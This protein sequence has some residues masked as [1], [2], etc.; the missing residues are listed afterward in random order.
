MN[1]IS[2]LF[3]IFLSLNCFTQQNN[4]LFLLH[5]LPQSNLMNPATP[6]T[7]KWYVG[8]P[9][10]SSIHF[11]Y[12]NSSFSYNQI[13]TPTN[14]SYEPNVTGLIKRL[15]SRNSISTELH[16][17][18]FALAYRKEENSF[19]FTITEKNNFLFTYP[20]KT[21][22][23]LLD[24]NAQ[25]VGEKVGITGS[26]ISFNHYREY[27]L[28]WSHELNKKTTFGVKGKLLFGKLN[29]STKTLDFNID[30]DETTYNL[31]FTGELNLRMSLPVTVDILDNRFNGIS[32]NDAMSPV[33]L[34]LNRKNPGFAIDLGVI[35]KYSRKVELSASI[36]DLGFIRWKSNL[37]NLN[38]SGEFFFDGFLDASSDSFFKNLGDTIINAL[39]LTNN[40][41]KYV[42]FLSPKLMAGANYKINE[43]F[44]SG[45]IAQ[46]SIH[47]RK[48]MTSLTLMGQF[49]P[50]PWFG[51]AASYSFQNYSLNNLGAGIYIGKRGAQFYVVSDNLLFIPKPL[52]TRNVNLR[53]GVNILFGCEKKVKGSK[54]NKSN[55]FTC[56]GI[57]DSERKKYRENFVPWEQRKKKTKKR[58]SIL[59]LFHLFQR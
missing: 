46:T 5:D 34:A 41:D 37:S 19:Y 12:A 32:Y 59:Q 9:V 48:I 36:I 7:C 57:S 40:Q 15:H 53:L 10:L 24:G 25:F 18:L 35:H 11:N 23:L 45:A 42:T 51:L 1:K 54:E 44:S 30:S 4:T 49:N 16:L 33:Q 26:G 2:L 14:T 38:A 17:Q 13:F 50:K 6:L 22:L 29:I 56:F 31:D 39:N 20:K 27:A 21:I 55:E 58:K 3:F 8:I 52:D 43:R 47:R 28:G